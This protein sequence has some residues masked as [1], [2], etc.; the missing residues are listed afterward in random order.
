MFYGTFEHALDEKNRLMIPAR[1]REGVPQAEGGVFYVTQ[2]L[3]HCLF[4]YTASGWQAAVARLQQGRGG[5]RTANARN[6]MRMFFSHAMREELDAAGRLLIPDALRKLAGLHREVSL[7]GVMDRIE[8]WDRARWTRLER[9][10]QPRYEKF[11][12][13]AELFG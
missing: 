9:S 4:A 13:E 11:A 3:D 10:N 8:I 12:E 6:F 5:L 2:G 7:V 1:L